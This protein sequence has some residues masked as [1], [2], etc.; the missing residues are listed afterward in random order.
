VGTV[1]AILF[2]AGA[3]YGFLI[4]PGRRWSW[5]WSKDSDQDRGDGP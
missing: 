5:P 4:R 1:L 2:F 3:I